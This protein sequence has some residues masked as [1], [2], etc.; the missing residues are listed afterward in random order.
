MTLGATLFFGFPPTQVIGPG[1][2]TWAVGS[3]TVT[4]DSDASTEVFISATTNCSGAGPPTRAWLQSGSRFEFDDVAAGCKTLRVITGDRRQIVEEVQVFAEGSGAPITI[5]VPNPAG[6]TSSTASTVSVERLRHPVPEK[7][8]RLMSEAN[9]LWKAGRVEQAA[10]K[11]RPA[12]EHYPEFWELR[13]NLGVIEMKLGNI[14]T[15]VNHFLKGREL[16]KE[17]AQLKRAL[18]TLTLEKQVLKDIAEGN[19]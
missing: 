15:A 7:A 9:R 18:A 13:M 8:V 14:E 19:F 1:T 11:L 12:V 10:A 2:G 17:N 3:I 6:H 4:N 5:R 16:Q